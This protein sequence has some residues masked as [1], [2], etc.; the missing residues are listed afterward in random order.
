MS[1]HFSW[2][3]DI[4]SNSQITQGD[5]IKN[6]PVPT[7]VTDDEYPYFQPVNFDSDVIIMTQACDIENNKVDYINICRLVSLDELLVKQV[8]EHNNQDQSPIKSMTEAKGKQRERATKYVDQLINGNVLNFYL[9]EKHDKLDN[10]V[11]NLKET[12]KIPFK[13]MNFLMEEV[14]VENRLRLQPP[15]R[16]HL[17]QQYAN[18]FGRIGLPLDVN[19]SSLKQDY[20]LK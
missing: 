6:L 16:E 10:R 2:F 20:N 1:N 12:F 17:S 18:I 4:T 5:I 11:V 13:A 8:N 7:F 15:Y 3:E 19:K 9:L 14:K